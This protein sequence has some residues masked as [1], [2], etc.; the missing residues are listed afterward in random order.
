LV[1]VALLRLLLRGLHVL[2]TV[3]RLLSGLSRTLGGLLL[4]ERLLTEALLR[5]GQ[6]LPQL[7]RGVVQFLLTLLLRGIRGLWT[8][9]ELFHLLRGRL[10]LS[11][12]LGRSLR[13]FRICTR[14]IL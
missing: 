10:L 5:F 9:T 6:L 4:I 11:R 14:V 1:R 12:Q 8:L 13:E 7:L 2:L 3:R